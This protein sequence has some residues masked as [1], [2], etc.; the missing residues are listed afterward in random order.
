MQ[1]FKDSHVNLA[2]FD[3]SYYPA[4]MDLKSPGK[5]FLQSSSKYCHRV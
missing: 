2:Y 1:D 3:P 5:K 4:I